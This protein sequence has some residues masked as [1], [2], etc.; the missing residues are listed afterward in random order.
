MVKLD[1]GGR[2]LGDGDDDE[3]DWL[4]CSAS[5]WRGFFL[6]HIER[7]NFKLLTLVLLIIRLLLLL[8]LLPLLWLWLLAAAAAAAACEVIEAEDEAACSKLIKL[9][10]LSFELNELVEADAPVSE[11]PALF[12]CGLRGG[13]AG[14]T[15]C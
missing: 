3:L 2:G 9:N 13:A 14:A 7:D 8:L 4:L 6:E 11:A 12:F 10:E 1:E 15:D 5:D